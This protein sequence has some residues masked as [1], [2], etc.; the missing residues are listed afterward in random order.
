M[1]DRAVRALARSLGEDPG[2]LSWNCRLAG[3]PVF[4][5]LLMNARPLDIVQKTFTCR[6]FTIKQMRRDRLDFGLLLRDACAPRATT[7]TWNARAGDHATAAP[8]A[9]CTS[10]RCSIS[11]P[12]L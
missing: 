6:H 4:Q 7:R 8:P 9:N 10:L 11:L 2:G 5:V 1:L 12:A 3:A